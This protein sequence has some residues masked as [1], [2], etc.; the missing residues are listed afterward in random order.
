MVFSLLLAM[1]LAVSPAAQGSPAPETSELSAA[2]EAANEGLDA[3][4]L[5]AF[6]RVVAADPD[7]HEARLWIA[8]LHARMGD[9]DLA[10]P[11]YRSVLLE[12][13]DSIDAMLGVADSLLRRDAPVQAIEVL[14][15]AEGLAANNGDV[16][17]ALGRA[18]PAA[19]QADQAID[20][21]ERA[22][23]VA[24][25]RRNLLSLEAARLFYLHRVETSA[26]QEQFSGA[27]PDSTLGDLALNIRLTN[28][29]RLLAQGQ[30]QRKLDR[31]E[32][33]G[34]AGVEW[35]FA[36]ATTLRVVALV[37]PNNRV[38]P[39]QDYFVEVGHTNRATTWSTTVRYFDFAGTETIIFSP[40]VAW[41]PQSPLS[42]ALGYTASWTD[43]RT[44]STVN[45]HS[46]FLRTALR[47][48]PRISVQGGYASG[49]EDFDRFSIDR[50]GDFRAHTVSGGLRVYLPTM[51]AIVGQYEYQT[52]NRGPKRD[53]G[54]ATVSLVQT[55]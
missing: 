19:D 34:G 16:L 52:R 48:H 38:A 6:E 10:E 20:Y 17:S 13:P 1:S 23:S 27:T 35:R 12:D 8:L 39:E 46:A 44:T 28:R 31:T 14:E 4:A 24:P 7:N 2:V 36:S 9:H 15:V 11:V 54:R 21:L 25:T 26:V 40:A 18:H 50:T 3:E 22:V 33:R 5:A 29:W 41:T 55:F 32:E 43:S 42:L 37:G 53:M 51:T 30:V 45:G 49:V 47:V